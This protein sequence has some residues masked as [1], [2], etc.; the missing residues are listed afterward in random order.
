M[1]IDQVRKY[2]AGLPPEARRILKRMREDIRAAVPGAVE[3]FSYGIPGFKLDGKPL[4]WYAAFKSHISMFP[5]GEAIRRKYAREL[6][7]LKTAKGTIQ[8]PL[9]E[10]P[11]SSLVKKLVTARIAEARGAR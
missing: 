6:E 1:A 8:F 7:G 10:P 4:V 11:S 5:M 3:H 9:A 2:F